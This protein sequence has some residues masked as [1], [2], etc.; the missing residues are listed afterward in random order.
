MQYNQ[1]YPLEKVM[2]L[3][4]QSKEYEHTYANSNINASRKYHELPLNK[5]APRI[6]LPLSVKYQK[7]ES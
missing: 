5:I 7:K 3:T 1:F 6:F 4:A 2:S